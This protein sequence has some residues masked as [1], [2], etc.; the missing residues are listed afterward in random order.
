MP[1]PA[2]SAL[3]AE[4]TVEARDIAAEIL[5]RN[6]FAIKSTC[7][8]ITAWEMISSRHFDLVVTDPGLPGMDGEEL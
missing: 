5:L 1:I 3:L 7:D 8:G 6:G 4:E 2:E